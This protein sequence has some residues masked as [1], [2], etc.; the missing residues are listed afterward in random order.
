MNCSMHTRFFTYKQKVLSFV[1]LL[2]SALTFFLPKETFDSHIG[3]NIDIFCKSLDS[4]NDNIQIPTVINNEHIKRI[5]YRD[6]KE[7]VVTPSFSSTIPI[8][9]P[10]RLK[11]MSRASSVF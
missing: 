10:P 1:I 11:L 4:I 9:S 7:I 8:R 6:Y 3:I 5:Y 2:V